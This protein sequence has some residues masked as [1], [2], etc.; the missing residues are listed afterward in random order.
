MPGLILD[1]ARNYLVIFPLKD[2]DHSKRETESDCD[3]DSDCEMG[4]SEDDF[5]DNDHDERV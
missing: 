1:V 5:I 4:E 3:S 2:V